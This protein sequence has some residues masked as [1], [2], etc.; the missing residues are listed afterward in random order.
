MKNKVN[1][2]RL[3]LIC[4]VKILLLSVAFLMGISMCVLP[5]NAA[6]KNPVQARMTVSKNPQQTKI[7]VKV[8][9]LKKLKSTE[10]LK[11]YVWTEW[12]GKIKAK[13]Y[14]VRPKNGQYTKTF[15]I[16]EH[17]NASG[18]YH[19]MAYVQRGSIDRFVTQKAVCIDGIQS[20]S[21]R[22]SNV[23]NEAGSCQIKVYDVKSV[24][25]ITKVKI[26]AYRKKLGEQDEVW[27]T[28]KKKGEQWVLD[29]DTQEHD[30]ASGKYVFEAKVWDER[31]VSQM[32]KGV[33][34]TIKVSDKIGVVFDESE[35]EKTCPLTVKNV[36]Y[37]DVENV[38]VDIWSE[39][40]GADDRKTYKMKY[41]KNGSYVTNLKYANH[42]N[43]GKYNAYIYVKYNGE[44][45]KLVKR[46][47]FTVA[48]IVAGRINFEY[49]NGQTGSVQIKAEQVKSPTKITEVNVESHCLAGG[50]NDLVSKRAIAGENGMYK[51]NI[52]VV[53]HNFQTGRYQVDV[54]VTDERGIVQIFSKKNLDLSFSQDYRNK[55]SFQGIDVSRYQGGINWSQVKAAG[56]DYAMIQVA[57]RDGT[58]G[59][60]M[61]D[62]YF[63]TNIQ[64]ALAAGL[65]VGVYFFSQAITEEE[66]KQE[67]D[68]AMKLVEP[69]KITYPICIDSEYRKNGRANSLNAAVRTNV[70]KAFCKEVSDAGYKG[71]VY[72]SK[73]WFEDNL[74]M[75]YLSDY[76]VWLARYYVVPE[77]TGTFHMWQ[78][79][80]K[81]R[82]AGISTDVDRDICYKRYY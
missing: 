45:R 43:T 6:A 18:N 79:T 3:S 63:R 67:A 25:E 33:E 36:R 40:N 26:R 35:A 38:Q 23:D 29:F 12:Y 24:A 22:I 16:A 82:V 74:Y 41:Q 54:K 4:T 27:Y 1:K 52:S 31:G 48:P 11:L 56:I 47:S 2:G 70:V 42:K 21:V 46:T 9:F 44:K 75:S 68:Y 76:E 57:Y 7:T 14:I 60:L 37:T 72:A 19:V 53:E 32:L 78:Y 66:A 51:S 80:N 55:T 61:E 62:R 34:K 77:Y 15:S 59:M 8:K 30:F 64:G 69:Y 50:R 20:G 13:S 71:M 58:S 17:G 39:K 28:A 5:G 10:H 49:Q 81:G 73:S 65:E